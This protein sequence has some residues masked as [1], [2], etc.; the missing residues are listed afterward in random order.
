MKDKSQGRPSKYGDEDKI[1]IAREYLTGDLSY[2]E[3]AKKYGFENKETVRH[4]VDWYKQHYQVVIADQAK[5]PEHSPCSPVAPTMP[6]KAVQGTDKN[7]DKE[8]EQARLKIA[9]LEL[10]IA[11]AQKELGIDLIKKLGTKQSG[12]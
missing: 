10:L 4:F 8:L 1:A 12:K 3:L 7:K 11:N 9:A 5:P 2:G 6:Q